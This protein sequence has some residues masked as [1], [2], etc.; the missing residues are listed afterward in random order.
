MHI[1][2]FGAAQEVGRSSIMLHDND[3]RIMFDYGVKLGKGLEYPIQAPDVDA[4][5]LSHAHLDHC[6]AIPVLYRH[7]PDIPA[8]GTPPSLDLSEL[9]LKDSLKIAR[10]E[11]KKAHF[12]EAQ[13]NLYKRRYRRI[14]YGMQAD[15]LG[16]NIE[17][18]DAGH[19]AGSA[20]TLLERKHGKENKRIVY[21]GDF[22]LQKQVLH[23]GAKIV[24]GDLLIMESTYATRDH[25]DKAQLVKEFIAKIKETLDNR[26]NVLLPVFAV[27]RGQ[28]L[29]TLLYE[30]G[31]AQHT[32]VDGMINSATE[33]ILRHPKYITHPHRLSD[34]V[35][36]SNRIRDSTD[37]RSVLD[38]PSI[39]LTTAG[40]LEGG[41][42]LNYITRLN[43]ESRIFLTGFQVEG[44]NGR[45]L[46]EKK[47]VRIDGVP[48]KIKTPVQFFDFSAHAGRE[49]LY[50]YAR[51][52][53]PNTIICVHG[54][55]E[56]SKALA[57][58]LSGEGF[59]AHAP[60]VGD[61][62][63]LAD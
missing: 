56:N 7:K 53:S 54:S 37:R 4:L 21:T 32:Y 14:P 62:I 20:I 38:E 18:Q 28:E 30:N 55:E 6:G 29:L 35:E 15:L 3:K 49:D 50:R 46:L 45:L 12:T 40:M 36:E 27:G 52:C 47:Y 17:M 39:I 63:K 61:V 51:E 8:I 44:T 60:K 19:V 23:D 58:A 41:P 22:K 13:M 16:M 11:H 43:E 57:E 34:A 48:H 31:L 26:G 10:I 2:F 25:P 9:L 1:S 33:I 5:I 59:D 42:V 24:K